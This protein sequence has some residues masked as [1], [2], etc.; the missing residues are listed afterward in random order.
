MAAALLFS[1]PSAGFSYMRDG[2]DGFRMDNDHHIKDQI[3]TD[4]CHNRVPA[5]DIILSCLEKKHLDSCLQ[6]LNRLKTVV[7][8]ANFNLIDFDHAVR[9]AKSYSQIGAFSR[10]ELDFMEQIFNFPAH[11]YGF[12]GEKTISSITHAVRAEDTV[13]IPRTGH[14]LFKGKPEALYHTIKNTIGRQV[15]LTS[16][17]RGIIK[18]F[19]LFFSKAGTCSGNL[20]LASRS[21]APPGYSY[22]GTGDFDV[23]QKGFGIYNFTEDFIQTPVYGKLS[24]LG[25]IRFRYTRNNNLGVRFEP[26]HIEVV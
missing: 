14:Y 12:L 4:A 17:V 8:Y 2:S 9:C 24:K 21:L 20:S 3:A 22:H 26:W 7:G 25:Y 15:V 6:K 1:H 23:G 19:H 13:K 16:G 5:N 11:R 10:Q 18:Q